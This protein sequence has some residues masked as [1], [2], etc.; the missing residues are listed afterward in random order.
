MANQR[1]DELSLRL[2]IPAERCFLSNAL[3]TLDGICD[4]YCFSECSRD[5]IKKALETALIGSINLSYQKAP[6]LFDLQFSVF[7]D[8]ITIAVEDF[9][10][11]ETATS[12]EIVANSDSI[13]QMLGDIEDMT[14]GITFIDKKGRNACY[15]MDFCVE[16][17]L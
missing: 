5:R 2:R 1:K 13:K 17:I 8:R 14:D 10:I 4:H 9:L 3:L 6:G 11:T 7:K 16:S 12:A 15:S